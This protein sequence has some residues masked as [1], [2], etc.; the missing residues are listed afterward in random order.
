MTSTI[1]I[2]VYRAILCVTTGPSVSLVASTFSY[3][4]FVCT[5]TFN[6]MLI[7]YPG[8]LFTEQRSTVQ[9]G[10]LY[11]ALHWHDFSLV[12]LSL[13]VPINKFF[14]NHA[15][16]IVNCNSYLYNN[17]RSIPLHRCIFCY[18]LLHG[19]VLIVDEAIPEF[20]HM[21]NVPH[22]LFWQLLP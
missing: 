17:R 14:F 2:F 21:A 10:P 9:P 6:L 11:P 22:T 7:L 13:Q 4:T 8:H 12:L 5:S 20:W 18:L 3:S 19:I 1:T 15:H 16:Y